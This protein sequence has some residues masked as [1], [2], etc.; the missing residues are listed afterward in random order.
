MLGFP[1][2]RL[3]GAETLIGDAIRDES[4]NE[5]SSDF[6]GL[7]YGG[8][9]EKEAK[10]L[11]SMI[12]KQVGKAIKNV[13][14]FYIS[15]TTDNLKEVIRKELEELKRG[16][17]MND[18]RNEMA[19]YHDFTACDVPKFDGTLDPFACTKWLSAVEGDFRTSRC[20]EKNKV[21]FASNFLR[22]SAKICSVKVYRDVEIEIDDSAFKIELIPIVLGAFDIVIGMDWLDRYNANILCSQKLIR[23]VNS[24]GRE[25]IIYKDKRKGEFKLCSMMK[26]R[27]YMSR[28][29]QA[30]MAHVVDTNVEKKSAKD[31]PVV[32]EFLDVFLEDFPSILPERQVEFRID[33]ISGATPIAKIPYCLAPSEMKELMTQL[34]E[35]PDKGFIRPSSSPWRV[36]GCKSVS[37]YNILI[38]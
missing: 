16:G 8:F 33:L 2:L 38:K 25:I 29:C 30:Y 36:I 21:N 6:E 31:V 13:M 5:S 18:S 12:T 23:V 7:N 15:Q 34:Q 32:K 26:A 37:K 35:L 1:R 4:K 22:D 3:L 20:K 27:K 28:G 10:A 11:R 14:P 19:T 17:M 9:T 24:Q